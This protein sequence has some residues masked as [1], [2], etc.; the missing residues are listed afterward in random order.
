MSE[1]ICT[2]S[3]GDKVYFYDKSIVIFFNRPFRNWF[4]SSFPLLFFGELWNTKATITPVRMST[5][6]NTTK[7]SNAVSHPPKKL[8][9]NA[10]QKPVIVQII[11]FISS[12]YLKFVF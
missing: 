3:T 9:R 6:M 8:A 1:Q 11:S 2:L 7:H 12:F 4:D 10:A 5:T